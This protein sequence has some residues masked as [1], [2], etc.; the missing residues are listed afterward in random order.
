ML[1]SSDNPIA[2]FARTNFRGEHKPF[3]IRK[4]DRDSHMYIIGRTGT[5][6]STLLETLIR[7]DLAQG[8]GVALLD[9]HGD[10]VEKIVAA[11]PEKR[12]ADLVYFN[13]PDL[14]R[15]MGFNPL[16]WVPP[17]KRPLAA[18]HMIEV[19]KKIWADTWGPRMEH[20]LRNTLLTLLEQPEATLADIHRL[21]Y[22]DDYRRAAVYRLSNPQVKR[23]WLEEFARY[24]VRYRPEAI[25]P[26]QNKVGAFLSD[27][28]LSRILTQPKSSF[29]V[30]EMMDSGK[31]FL[32]NLA[33]GKIGEDNATLLGALLVSR[34]GLAALSRA[35]VAEESR[36]DFFVYLDEFQNFTTLALATMLSELRKYHLSLVLA[37]QYLGQLDLEVRDAVLGNVGTMI[38]FRIGLQDAKVLA[39]EFHPK[40]ED[41][42]LMNLPNYHIYLKIMID[43]QVSKPFSGETVLGLGSAGKV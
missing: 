10:L 36:R 33:K 38:S 12:K 2:V 15:P 31:I 35:D 19:F 28:N 6:K 18:S 8:H 25:A 27:P 26:I 5:G 39:K 41:T 29:N 37:H 42:D 32:V 3:G 9:P 13:V 34:L 23:F 16:E 21:F 24:S 40:V 20:I 43:G 14:S 11:I 30:R 1:P 17:H 4:K 22:S 7:Q